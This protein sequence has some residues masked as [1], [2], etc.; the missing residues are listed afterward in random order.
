MDPFKEVT[1][2]SPDTDV[3]LLLVYYQPNLCSKTVFRTG[4]GKDVRDIDIKSAYEVIGSERV[5]ALL[6]YHS[7]T[8]CD[9][10]AKFNGKSKASTWKQFV[11]YD[12]LQA[13]SKLAEQSDTPLDNCFS[14]SERFVL[15]LYCPKRPNSVATF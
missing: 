1:I 7:I 2:C 14:G 15:D 3:F 9:F 4:H 12:I 6:G 10:T 11:S 8:G 5:S 13:F